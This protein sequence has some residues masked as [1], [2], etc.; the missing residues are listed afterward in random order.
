MNALDKIL[1]ELKNQGYQQIKYSKLHGGIN[2]ETYLIESNS[3]KFVL[4]IYIENN[5]N[6]INRLKVENQFLNFLNE[7][8]INNVPKVITTNKKHN[9][10][11][12]SWIDGEKI[13]KINHF[14]CSQLLDFLVNLQTYRNYE[15]AINLPIASD[16]FF[17]MNNCLLSV[18][19]RLI[20]LILK[21]QKICNVDKNLSLELTS[22]LKQN[23]NNLSS[24]VNSIKESNVDKDYVLPLKDRILSQS[25]VGFHNIICKKN[26]V[27]FIDFEY[28][29]WDDPGKLFCDLLIQPD[30]NVPLKY[31]QTLDLFV[32]N[33]IFKKNYSKERLFFMLELS[34][35][36]WSLIIL[37]PILNNIDSSQ[38]NLKDLIEIKI[39]KSKIYL[40]EGLNRIEFIKNQILKNY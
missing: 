7:C 1:I 20:K 18:N 3:N 15:S 17:T 22:F 34:R 30:H 4:K 27:Y 14:L 6:N 38:E 13:K 24:L 21:N 33:H 35:I 28:S 36:K 39:N 32:Y 31:M 25:D 23:I 10:L 12:I 2:S 19:K 40:K 26:K 11:L 9:W 5:I 16:A 8:N 37:N 29:G